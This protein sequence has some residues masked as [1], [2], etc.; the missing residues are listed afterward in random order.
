MQ[1]LMSRLC[2]MLHSRD[3]TKAT[4]SGSAPS[5][6]SESVSNHPMDIS[7]Y[8]SACTIDSTYVTMPAVTI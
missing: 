8:V 6:E 1:G 5:S 4:P 3:D 7:G 2:C